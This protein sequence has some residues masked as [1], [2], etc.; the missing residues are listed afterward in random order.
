MYC[1][2]GRRSSLEPRYA[3]AERK[4]WASRL[5][6]PISSGQFFQL[7]LRRIGEHDPR[8]QGNIGRQNMQCMS[9]DAQ[10]EPVLDLLVF[11]LPWSSLQVMPIKSNELQRI[12]R[13]AMVLKRRL[14]PRGCLAVPWAS[15]QQSSPRPDCKL[16]SRPW[17]AST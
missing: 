8:R 4:H 7:W 5:P 11:V 13:F 3:S 2:A 10:T 15:M 9:G 1:M 12:T 16:H 17:T 6:G 14:L